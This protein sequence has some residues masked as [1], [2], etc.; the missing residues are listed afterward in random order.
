MHA[1]ASPSA[2][3]EMP[4]GFAEFRLRGQTLE[5]PDGKVIAAADEAKQR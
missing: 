4:Q 1:I 3:R 5:L 2:A